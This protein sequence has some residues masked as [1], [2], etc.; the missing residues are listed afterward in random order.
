VLDST[1][2]F[3]DIDTGERVDFVPDSIE[4]FGLD[5]LLATRKEGNP[6]VPL[7]IR[8]KNASIGGKK[9]DGRATV[10]TTI[11]FNQS[12]RPFALVPGGWSPLA[13]SCTRHFLIDRNILSLL[14]QLEAGKS[15]PRLERLRWWW[16]LVDRDS[17][18]L[19]P[20]PA[21]YEGDRRQPISY[22]EFTRAFESAARQL[23]NMVS[24]AS[25]VVLGESGQ[26][27]AYAEIQAV[28]SRQSRE[29]EL[30]QH[31]CPKIL[32]NVVKR[33]QRRRACE[34]ILAA[35]REYQLDPFS[36]IGLCAMS[37]LYRAQS[38]GDYSIGR[39]L[40]KPTLSYD[41]EDAY[42]ALSDLRHLEI[43]GLATGLFV[44]PPAL[45][46][47]DLAMAALWTV[48]RAKGSYAAQGCELILNVAPG[49]FT[50]LNAVDGER[51]LQL[52]KT[53]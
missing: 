31:I 52:L 43:S 18:S 45:L 50:G 1:F 17:V 16:S 4:P 38:G 46:T 7:V 21:A 19:N 5:T 13:L 49:L 15:T 32:S 35:M 42:N 20:L 25:V 36:L 9:M 47:E 10:T 40:L 29:A 22:N 30:L 12:P 24:N 3:H 26:Q 27:A 14:A 44:E 23:K 2:E 53:C 34:D 39:E 8:S 33:D 41:A 11:E 28:Q 51:L 37:A 48:L 6:G